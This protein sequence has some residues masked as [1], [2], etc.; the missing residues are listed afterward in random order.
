MSRFWRNV[1]SIWIGLVS[2]GL[3]GLPVL[4]FW[5][6]L[7]PEPLQ[8]STWGEKAGLLAFVACEL[9]FGVA[10]FRLCRKLT[11]RFVRDD[12]SI[13]VLFR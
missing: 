12:G 13:T 11:R 1:L 7:F 9:L 10:G 8:G 4:I 3:G 6:L 5:P 2:G